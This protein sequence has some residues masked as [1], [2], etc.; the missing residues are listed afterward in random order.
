MITRTA[1]GKLFVVGEYAVV[2]SGRQAIVMPVD[3]RVSV[4]VAAAPAPLPDVTIGSDMLSSTVGFTRSE[5][6]LRPTIAGSPHPAKLRHVV[7]AIEVVQRFVA[8]R[9]LPVLP[10]QVAITSELHDDG[11]KLGLGS[12]GAVTV[13]TV[14][15]LSAF[16]GLDLPLEQRFRLAMLAT[17]RV[18]PKSSGGDLAA[19]TWEDWVAYS[20][21]DRTEILAMTE[22]FGVDHTIHADWPG[23][24]VQRLTPPANLTLEVGWTGTPSSSPV[25]VAG[26][27]RHK[28]KYSTFYRSFLWRSDECVHLSLAALRAGDSAGLVEQI[29]RF[30]QLM[31]T[32]DRVAR[33]GI[34]TDRLNTLCRTAAEAG[35][36]AKPSGSGGGDCGIAAFTG[37]EQPELDHLRTR[38]RHAGIRPLAINIPGDRQ[39]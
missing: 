10:I 21:P 31:E 9:G 28:R 29:R 3:R 22:R 27:A 32:A 1:P 39:R 33:V 30:R 17:A 37:A 23:L 18:D 15:A 20:A 16:H 35:G 6:R 26:L 12:S 25:M 24:S 5:V 8:E 13:A 7:S 2:E 34:F 14:A 36:E 4:T 38:W 11:I 19:S